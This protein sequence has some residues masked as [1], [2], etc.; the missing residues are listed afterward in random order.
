M[1]SRFFLGFIKFANSLMNSFQASAKST[2]LNFVVTPKPPIRPSR[3]A[4]SPDFLWFPR[5][6]FQVVLRGRQSTSACLSRVSNPAATS[7]S[8]ILLILP[9]VF[10]LHSPSSRAVMHRSKNGPC[11]GV[12]HAS[13]GSRLEACRWH[14]WLPILRLAI[15][16]LRHKDSNRHE[17]YMAHDQL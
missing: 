17:E 12:P 2:L 3:S 14:S 15:S 16:A 1:I 5:T 10:R 8:Q 6:T 7:A 11:K 4:E 13:R 9:R